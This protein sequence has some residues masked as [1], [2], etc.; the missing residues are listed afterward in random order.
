[1]RRAERLR[2]MLLYSL[3]LDSGSTSGIIANPKILHNMHEVERNLTVG[4]LAG[5]THINKKALLGTYS[6][7]IWY[8]PE[9]KVNILSLNKIRKYYR[10]TINTLKKNC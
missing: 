9:G 2:F 5:T 1:M 8:Y 6:P 10:C 7:S 3:I 4:S